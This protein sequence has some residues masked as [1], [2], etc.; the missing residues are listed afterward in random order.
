MMI[1]LAAR[2]SGKRQGRKSL[3]LS[4]FRAIPALAARTYVSETS[5]LTAS[6]RFVFK[7]TQ[8]PDDLIPPDHPCRI[9]GFEFQFPAAALSRRL[10]LPSG[11]R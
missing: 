1:Q 11:V 10:P 4:I 5:S 9:H 8:F 7:A 2:T 3:A 6:V